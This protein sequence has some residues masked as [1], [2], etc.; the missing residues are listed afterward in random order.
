VVFSKSWC[1]YSRG[2]KRTL[3]NAGAKYEHLELDQE[4]DGDDIQEA[5]YKLT[6]QSTVPNI[7]IGKQHIGGN[8]E[9]QRYSKKDLEKLLQNAGALKA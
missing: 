4:Q 7:F 2:A 8:S 1:S 6:G 5:L 9:L 3:D